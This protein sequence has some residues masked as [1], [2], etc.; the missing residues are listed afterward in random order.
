MFTA[1]MVMNLF[2]SLIPDAVL[3]EGKKIFSK[4]NLT[5][6]T[7]KL[8]DAIRGITSHTL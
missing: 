6:V 5:K 3:D 4:D 8:F 1:Y 2:H 7:S